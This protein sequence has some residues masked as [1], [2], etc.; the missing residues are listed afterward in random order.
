V[1]ATPVRVQGDKIS[2]GLRFAF[3]QSVLPLFSERGFF[4]ASFV[5]ACSLGLRTGL[6]CA[7][8]EALGDDLTLGRVSGQA[9]RKESLR[10]HRNE[11]TMVISASQREGS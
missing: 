5:F 8:A 4:S 7:F 6:F 11:P 2:N 1:T 9:D 10:E 3:N